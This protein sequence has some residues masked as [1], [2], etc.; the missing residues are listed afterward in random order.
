ME[1]KQVNYNCDYYI[2]KFRA[3]PDSQWAIGTR[4][5]DDGSK[6]ALGHLEDDYYTS[7][8]G[9]QLL[10][11]IKLFKDMSVHI[12]KKDSF[13]AYDI[14]DIV[15]D[16]RFIVAAINNGETAEYQQA[17][18]KERILAVLEDIKAKLELTIKEKIVYVTV[19]EPV[20]KLQEME[21]I[22]N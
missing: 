3:I 6:C 21:L 11:I 13:N 12:I 15:K 17:T 8:H 19:D 4:L 10:G 7:S 1:N 18:P 14:G 22:Q 5:L 20:R 2:D 9:C 16:A